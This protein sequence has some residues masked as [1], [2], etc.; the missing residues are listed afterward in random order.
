MIESAVQ[1]ARQL[2]V[3]GLCLLLVTACASDDGVRAKRGGAGGLNERAVIGGKDKAV[4]GPV[5]AQY[6]DAQARELQA[7]AET[8]RSGDGIIVTLPEKLLFKLNSGTLDPRSRRVLRKIAAI[9]GKYAK[10]HLTVVGH[11]DDRGFADFDIHLSERRAKAVADALVKSGIP[12]SRIRIMGMGFA[13]PIAGNDT[14]EGRSR[15]RRVEIH[16]AP[17][18]QLRIEDRAP[19]A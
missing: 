6:M 19:S 11:T 13:R 12:R 9:I 3:Y 18:E 14:A 7:L 17:D 4:V 2:L 8:L 5:I 15:N 10:T 1:R 16:I